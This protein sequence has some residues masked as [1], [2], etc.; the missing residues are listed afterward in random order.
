MA[1]TVIAAQMYT[2]RKFTQ[3]PADIAKTL[4]KVRAIGY[5]A[6]QISA[7]G[8]IDPAELARMLQGE[9]LTVASTHTALEPLLR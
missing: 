7:F 6:I 4:A 1:E 3:T 5:E 8:P 9:G 2:L